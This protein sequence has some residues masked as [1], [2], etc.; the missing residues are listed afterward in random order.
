MYGHSEGQAV[1]FCVAERGQIHKMNLVRQLQTAVF[2]QEEPLQDWYTQANEP[3][4]K[5]RCE[6]NGRDKRANQ[7]IK[8]RDPEMGRNRLTTC[9]EC[10]L[11]CATPTK[12][13]MEASSFYPYQYGK[14]CR[15]NI[16]LSVQLPQ[17]IRTYLQWTWISLTSS[18][19]SRINLIGPARL[20]NVDSKRMMHPYP[21][22]LLV[23]SQKKAC[24][25]R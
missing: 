21:K 22:F 11:P 19:P 20:P 2:R 23:H 18:S 17:H 3:K 12:W 4:R 9:F 15:R 10:L 14:S 24:H 13:A 25:S 8:E 16:Q 7:T 1:G 5:W 6:K